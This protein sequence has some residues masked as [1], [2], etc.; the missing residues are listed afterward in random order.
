MS[1]HTFNTVPAIQVPADTGLW[2]RNLV[3]IRDL[4]P[5]EVESVLHL[6]S[7]MKARPNDF[8]G[9]LT[10]KQMALFFEKPSLR[11]RLTFQAGMASLGGVSFFIDQT[12]SRLGEREA[13]SD[14]ARN[15]ER[16]IDVVVLRTFEH[17]TVEC[18]AKYADVPVINALSDLEH[19]CQALADYFTLQEKFTNI[20]DIRLA[21]VGDGNNVAHSLLLTCAALGSQIR[22]STPPGYEPDAQI[23]ADAQSLAQETGAV[24]EL[25]SDPHAAVCGVDAVYTDVWASMGQEHE[26]D[27]RASVF[28]SYQVNHGLLANASPHA[29]FMHCLPAH[30]GLEVTDEVIDS[31]RSVV[32]D[33][34]ENR[35]HVQKAIL[36]LLLGGGMS[37]L[38][39]RS[40]HA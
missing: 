32:F 1:S 20:R 21:Y 12:L 11:T 19:P 16:W 5:V 9:A 7:L 37:R 10:G 3:S 35:V 24:I 23:V 34:A 26:A 18:V 30:R 17:Q 36:L 13:L 29:L 25:I 40:A 15:L 6:A 28:A 33:Q 14:V 31:P 8:R 27:D 4:S 2:P 22:I 38:P 39:I